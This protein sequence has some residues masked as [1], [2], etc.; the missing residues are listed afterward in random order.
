MDK[1]KKITK[2][3]VLEAIK[4][5]VPEDIEITIDEDT[6]VTGADVHDYVWNTLAQMEAKAN[7]AKERAAEK[8]AEGDELRGVVASLL[9]EEFQT[10]DQIKAQIEGDDLT[11]AK[12]IARLSALVK[13]GEAHKTDLKINGGTRKG[14]AAGPAPEA[15]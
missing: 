13:A 8:R 4:T 15:E 1:V 14:Y 11:N 5:Y 9:T 7:K 3:Q 12:I 10:V 6:V 2:A